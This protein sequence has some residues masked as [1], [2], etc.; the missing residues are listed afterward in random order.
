VIYHCTGVH[1]NT[2]SEPCRSSSWELRDNN[3]DGRS[4]IVLQFT[5]LWS[6]YHSAGIWPLMR[7]EFIRCSVFLWI[8]VHIFS[9]WAAIK[10]GRIYE[11]ER[12]VGG[13]S[14]SIPNGLWIH[15][16]K[17]NFIP[18]PLFL[19]L[20]S[21]CLM[22]TTDAG[23]GLLGLTMPWNSKVIGSNTPKIFFRLLLILIDLQRL[24]W[25]DNATVLQERTY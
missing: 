15:G 11:R 17:N 22:Q 18:L 13:R 5:V 25:H 23:K 12:F 2:R 19:N 3:C 7:C 8:H 14:R 10:F 24:T 21:R 9:C 20:Q 16:A 6:E 1:C 4:D